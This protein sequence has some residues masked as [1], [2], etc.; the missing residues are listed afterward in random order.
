MK[1]LFKIILFFN[2]LIIYSCTS[3]A[4]SEIK[5]ETNII[6][7]SEKD[8]LYTLSN[9]MQIFI[10]EGTF[11]KDE[12][13]YL[14]YIPIHNDSDMIQNNLLTITNLNQQLKTFGMVF[15]KFKNDKNQELF[16]EKNYTIINNKKGNDE[17]IYNFYG[18]NS[19]KGI[20]WS[21][22]EDKSYLIDFKESFHTSTNGF[23][24]L[25]YKNKSLCE[26]LD[27]LYSN[28]T[29][30][31]SISGFIYF[32]RKNKVFTLDSIN[33]L[34]KLNINL[35]SELLEYFKNEFIYKTNVNSFKHLDFWS[36]GFN[37]I[38]V[39]QANTRKSFLSTMKTGWFNFDSY[40]DYPEAILKVS[41]NLQLNE[42]RL[43]S[44]SYDRC[45][46]GSYYK[47]VIQFNVPLEKEDEQV[48]LLNVVNNQIVEK[49]LLKLNRGKTKSIKW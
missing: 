30:N 49:K 48:Y 38:D 28:K 13:I 35:E 37:S 12:N 16:P 34:T 43:V 18:I 45:M 20:V 31:D 21:K 33:W 47:N 39:K 22:L 41:S 4:N 1:H 11:T 10:G 9:G 40:F 6:K 15:I 46:I 24:D 3:S 29:Y 26:F 25:I 5:V 27:S 32:S 23:I 17:E 7:I 36:I 42:F 19:S 2:I 14:E 8:S 44:S